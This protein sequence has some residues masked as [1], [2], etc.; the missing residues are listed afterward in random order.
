FHSPPY[1][2]YIPSSPTRRSSDLASRQRDRGSAVVARGARDAARGADRARR[3]EPDL[4]GPPL[5][6]GC[7][8]VLPARPRIAR[9]AD[10]GVRPQ[11]GTPHVCTPVTTQ[12]PIPPPP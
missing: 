10:R 6:D 11:I 9:W 3:A 2:P 1:T 7:V 4:P 12:S 5:A 8:G